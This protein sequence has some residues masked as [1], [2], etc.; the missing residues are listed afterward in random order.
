MG[1]EHDNERTPDATREAPRR[2]AGR[3]RSLP[4]DRQYAHD[5][6]KPAF[7]RM[8][9]HTACFS[10][11]SSDG[12][13]VHFVRLTDLS[14]RSHVWPQLDRCRRLPTVLKLPTNHRM[15]AP[16]RSTTTRPPPAGRLD[17]RS[18]SR[19]VVIHYGGAG[20]AGVGEDVEQ[21]GSTF[22]DRR[23][24]GEE[25]S[26]IPILSNVS[27]VVAARQP[28]P[29]DHRSV[30]KAGR[31]VQGLPSTGQVL[32]VINENVDPWVGL[33]IVACRLVAACS[34][35]RWSAGMPL[36]AS[37][38]LAGN[39]WGRRRPQLQESGCSSLQTLNARYCAS[40]FSRPSTSS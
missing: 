15:I 7:S 2:P 27:T 40:S 22:S 37:G 26:P 38:R 11:R 4:D 23:R 30:R 39:G 9:L 24:H 33:I 21:D 10:L 31:A 36:S 18:S 6:V 17:A 12:L 8:S 19:P 14:R 1:V 25:P 5:D 3:R 35:Q 32:T 13:H 20:P 16:A 28:L 29:R 34:S